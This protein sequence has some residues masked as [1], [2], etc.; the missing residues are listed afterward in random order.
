MPVVPEDYKGLKTT[1][2]DVWIPPPVV[3]EDDSND[4]WIN[5][6]IYAAIGVGGGIMLCFG[7]YYLAVCWAK[8]SH[9]VTYLDKKSA[10]EREFDRHNG[11]VE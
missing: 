3:T 6:A 1:L 2:A 5:I 11:V 9:K 7:C 4:A 10:A 8:R